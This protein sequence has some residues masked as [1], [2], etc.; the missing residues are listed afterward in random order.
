MD[1]VAKGL[2]NL[3]IGVAFLHSS[4]SSYNPVFDHIHCLQAWDYLYV[5]SYPVHLWL[6]NG[7]GTR[8]CSTLN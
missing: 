6:M 5:A 7:L 8:P 4:S 1:I 2:I 3:V